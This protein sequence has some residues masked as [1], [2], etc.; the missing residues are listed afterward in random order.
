MGPQG[1]R[2]ETG[3][4]AEGTTVPAGDATCEHGGVKF[5]TLGGDLYVC[6]G[7]PGAQGDTGETG[8]AG[9]PG[10]KGADGAPAAGTTVPVGDP[11]C[12]QGG[13]VF[14]TSTGDLYVCNGLAGEQG[15]KGDTGAAG[16]TGAQGVQ[17]PA[18]PVGPQGVAG[19]TGAAGPIGPQGPQGP[20]GPQGLTG[21]TGA[22][23]P[24]GLQGLTGATG[25][26]GLTG[27]V[28]PTG[29][30]GPQGLAGATGAQG[31][32]G[33][34]GPMGATGATG[35]QG[36]VG[37]TGPAGATGAQ[38]PQ[39]LAGPIGA[40]GATGPQGP[41]GQSVV[42]AT[43]APGNPFCPNG[44]S[45]FTSATGD[46]YACNGAVGATGATGPQ[47]PTGSTGAPGAVGATG[48]TGPQGPPGPSDATSLQGYSLADLQRQYGSRTLRPCVWDGKSV[49]CNEVCTWT[50][51]GDV[52]CTPG[53][54]ADCRWISVGSGNICPG[55]ACALS[56]LDFT[57]AGW[58]FGE[59]TSG[60]RML[61]VPST[62]NKNVTGRVSVRVRH[63]YL[64]CP[65]RATAFQVPV[66]LYL[67]EGAVDASLVIWR[68]T[69][70][71]NGGATLARDFAAQMPTLV[72][73]ALVA[74][75]HKYSVWISAG[76]V[77]GDTTAVCYL[78]RYSTETDNLL[79]GY[80][81]GVGG[82]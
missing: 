66:T 17:G 7:A 75:G 51:T 43:V 45:R 77:A 71:T 64:V 50:E 61:S 19:A 56:C 68:G 60:A 74:P 27:L 33:P 16:A 32:Q 36:L 15:P 70:L 24:Q 49:A 10:P 40:T 59:A 72:G 82:L 52:S 48:P 14:T 41:A 2:G 29:A 11:T 20:A 37:A 35:P 44:G 18:G 79:V 12:P 26:Q 1:P 21:A 13:A 81:P 76:P 6:N 73:D 46:T 63:P 3:A 80:E 65:Y 69:V 38:G 9:P 8:P 4:P 30:T 57:K 22:T 78:A 67:F 62:A 25:P 23:G 58:A 28:G 53:A 55:G 39:G 42:G 34:A 54:V 5:A 47:G 31:L